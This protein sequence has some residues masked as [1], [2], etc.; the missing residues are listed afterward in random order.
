MTTLP[1]SVS[2]LSRKCGSL[3]VSQSYGP[4]R[5]VTGIALIFTM[6]EFRLYCRTQQ[7]TNQLAHISLCITEFIGRTMSPHVSAHGAIIR[8]YI[9][10]PYTIELCLLYGSIYYTYH[11]VLK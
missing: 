6:Y 11:Y 1:P 9:N 4:P 7:Y 8:R 5:L 3:D 2:R 10:K